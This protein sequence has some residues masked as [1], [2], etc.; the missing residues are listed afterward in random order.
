MKYTAAQYT[1]AKSKDSAEQTFFAQKGNGILNQDQFE[2]QWRNS[3]EPRVYQLAN[4]PKDVAKK[5]IQE[6]K[7]EDR[8]AFLKKYAELK[9]M[10]AAPP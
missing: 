3:Y 6:M 8:A 1:A 9:G 7:P 10:G 4:E 2:K 5:T